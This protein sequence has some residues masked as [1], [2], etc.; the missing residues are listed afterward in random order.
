M[1][2]FE[3]AIKNLIRNK[4]IVANLVSIFLIA[5]FM[6]INFYVLILLI[7]WKNLLIN[8][9][10]LIALVPTNIFT[11]FVGIILIVIVLFLF[12]YIINIFKAFCLIQKN[13]IHTMSLLGASS[14]QIGVEYAIQP[15]V[16]LLLLLPIASFFGKVTVQRFENDFL[17]VLNL[18]VSYD[19]HL[20]E[21]IG[22]IT[23]FIL[24]IFLT[25]Y[26]YVKRVLMDS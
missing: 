6:F 21:V 3:N 4:G 11:F 5:F 8:K 1:I 25:I 7:S 17:S 24:V 14:K 13:D 22:I 20:V 23:F 15:V 10:N 19:N 2:Y 12:F 9:E 16:C 18:N 26:F